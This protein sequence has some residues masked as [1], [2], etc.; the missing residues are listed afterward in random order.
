[1]GAQSTS[2]GLRCLLD[3]LQGGC[4]CGS[5][6]AAPC[7]IIAMRCGS[8][9]G[10]PGTGPGPCQPWE[11]FRCRTPARS[12]RLQPAGEASAT[13]ARQGA[14]RGR[15]R[16]RRVGRGGPD[17]ARA[18]PGRRHLGRVAAGAGRRC[19][20]GASHG[21]RRAPGCG[22]AG[23]GAPGQVAGH[24][25]PGHGHGYMQLGAGCAPAR[26]PRVLL[27]PQP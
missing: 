23:G 3:R 16:V 13:R 24:R 10:M 17:G 11:P 5:L 2:S 15:A 4:A 26:R 27:S 6:P 22:P 25:A 12:M 20:R 14:R 9:A 7:A 19:G 8:P 21:R 1:V 18:R